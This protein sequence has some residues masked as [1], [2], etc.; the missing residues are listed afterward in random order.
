MGLSDFSM[1]DATLAKCKKMNRYQRCQFWDSKSLTKLLLAIQQ[2][3]V[4]VGRDIRKMEIREVDK[5]PI[6]PTS[7]S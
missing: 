5:T 2:G 6:V 3:Y 7:D 4:P 1:P